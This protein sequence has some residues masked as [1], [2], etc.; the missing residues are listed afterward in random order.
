MLSIGLEDQFTFFKLENFARLVF[1][2]FTWSSPRLYSFRG[3]SDRKETLL[4]KMLQFIQLLWQPFFVFESVLVFGL[5]YPNT[6][7]LSDFIRAKKL[8]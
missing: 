8:I 2:L 4:L 6:V 7:K 1:T 3:R 5:C